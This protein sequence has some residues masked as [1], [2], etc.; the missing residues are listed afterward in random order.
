MS[1]TSESK[2]LHMPFQ[3]TCPYCFKKTLVD[4]SIV[5]QKGPCVGCGK[6][7]TV[8]EP[9]RKIPDAAAPIGSTVVSSSQ[10]KKRPER[11]M[12]VLRVAGLTVSIVLAF[13]VLIYGLWP[14]LKGLRARRD[15]IACMSNLQQIATALNAYAKDHGTYPTPV[16]TDSAGKPLYSWRVLL[17]P[18]LNEPGLYARFNLGEAWD[19]TNNAQLI[20][21]CPSVYISPASIGNTSQASY[22][23]LTGPGTIFPPSGPLKPAQIADGT[24]Q[25]LLVVETNNSLSE[26]SKPFDLDVS[27]L[28]GRIGGAGTNK[29]GGTH[30]DGATGVFAD[31]QSAWL[32]TDLP[33]AILNAIISPNG[34]ESMPID[35]ELFRMR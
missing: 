31:G 34:S 5:G 23:L 27:K 17:L 19:S 7:I 32:A 15:A 21:L 14:T 30:F 8:P 2:L 16:V 10:L 33:S 22:V 4:E 6:V 26:W 18:Y 25:T 29:I 13:A 9:P 1:L 11:L 35:P 20:S 3:F 28:N 24:G 12:L